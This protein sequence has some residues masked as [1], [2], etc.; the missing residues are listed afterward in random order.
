MKVKDKKWIRIRIYL[1]AFFFLC[2]LTTILLR[3]FQL[4]VLE[5]DRLDSIARAGYRTIVK[6][7]PKRGTIY[8]RE[9]HELAVSVEMVSIY[10]DPNLIEDKVKTAEQLSLNLNVSQNS[11]LSL[12]NKN[13]SFVWIERKV[14]PEKIGQIRALGLKGVDF[15]LETRRYYPGRDIA[16]HLLGFVGSDNQGLEGLE[17]KYDELLTGPQQSLVQMRDALGRPFFVSGPADASQDLHNIVLTIDKDIQYKA[18]QA[19]EAAVEK[20]KGKSG[21]CLIMDPETGEILAMAV[22]PSFNPNIF[23]EYRP[24][25]WRNRTITD[26]YEPGS[27]IKPFLLAAALENNIVAP[28]TKFYCEKGEYPISNH[29]IHDTKK[30]GILSVSDIIV[31]SSNIGAVKMGQ[32]L[33]YGEFHEYLK[34]FGF[35][36]RT[37]IDLIGERQGSVRS[38]ET[39]KIIDKATVFFGHGMS[40]T[41]L[42]LVN[43]MAS[44]ANGGKL[45]KPFI[46]KSITDQNGQVIKEYHPQMI[47]RVLS[48]EITQKVTKILEGVVSERG[49]ATP[50]A[51]TGY[52]VAGK[53][54][55]S[56]KI[57]PLTKSYSDEDYVAIFVGFVPSKKP[58]LAIL[59][60]I[61]EPQGVVYGGLV[62]GPVFKEVGKWALNYMRINPEIALVEKKEPRPDDPGRQEVIAP[63][64]M[65][66]TNILPDFRGQ[67]MREVLKRGNDLGINVILDGTGM[68]FKQVPGPGSPTDE[69]ISVEVSFRPPM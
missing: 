26:C 31:L 1:V 4:Q 46:V 24:Y 49:T 41:S 59:V 27:T 39:S 21:Q 54:G 9:G 43:A 57:D 12:L 37:G 62:A 51:I 61:D 5:R 10:A 47:R 14:P 65:E 67:T 13:R 44:I 34:K 36:E 2:G 40:A 23:S 32:A 15:T 25:Q 38:P 69:I 56:E 29:I 28:N 6:L 42:Q 35:G 19:L 53:T 20:A 30:Y 60:M 45:M 17:K 50:A 11:I 55:T 63:V 18:Q 3:A 33:G 7:L 66:N 58:K 16:G 64:Q 22:A 52:G 68:A 48:K 8:D